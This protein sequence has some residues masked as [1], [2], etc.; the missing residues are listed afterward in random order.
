MELE[1]KWEKVLIKVRPFLEFYPIGI[2]HKS[3]IRIIDGYKYA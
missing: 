1:N 3:N 2:E